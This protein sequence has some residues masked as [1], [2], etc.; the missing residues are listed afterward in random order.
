MAVSADLKE[1]LGYVGIRKGLLEKAARKE[2]INFSSPLHRAGSLCAVTA[3]RTG[4][5]G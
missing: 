5:K 2:L 4:G 1:S 3:T